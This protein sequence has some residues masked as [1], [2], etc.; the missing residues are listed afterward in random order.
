MVVSKVFPHIK[1]D[2]VLAVPEPPTNNTPFC[3]KA[4]LE[5]TGFG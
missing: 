5:C 1:T 2:D 4:V 3:W